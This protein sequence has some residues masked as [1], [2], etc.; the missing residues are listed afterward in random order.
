MLLIF[1]LLVDKGRN[2]IILDQPEENLDNE[3]VVSPV[4]YT[5]LIVL[6]LDQVDVDAEAA[7]DPHEVLQRLGIG[8]RERLAGVVEDRQ[9]V[10]ERL[11][12]TRLAPDLPAEAVQGV[13][14]EVLLILAQLVDCLL[15]TSRCV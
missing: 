3:T 1:Y 8:R 2:P 15:Y 9:V 10:A 5:H 13:G 11:A 7:A 14:E 4:S 6:A 12:R